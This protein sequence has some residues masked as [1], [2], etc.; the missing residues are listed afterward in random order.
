MFEW[1]GLDADKDARIVLLHGAA[2]NAA[3]GKGEVDVLFAHTPYLERAILEQGGILLVHNTAGDVPPLT[4]LA[5][6]ALVVTRKA[7]ETRREDL[8]HMLEALHRAALL[9]HEDPPAAVRALK[10]AFPEIETRRLAKLVELYGPAFLSTP[11][12]P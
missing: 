6:H 8:K 4:G 2:Q 11:R 3:F 5:V 1:A 12:S 9:V 10:K 7:A